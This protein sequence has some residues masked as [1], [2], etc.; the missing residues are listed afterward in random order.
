MIARAVL[1]PD[2]AVD[3]GRFQPFRK[4]GAQ[5]KMIEAQTRIA[6]KPIS[7]VVLERIDARVRMERAQ[8]VGPALLHETRIGRSAFRLD[9]RVV[10]P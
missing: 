6:R 9:E 10:V 4:C 3:I 8:G 7:Q 1:A 5:Q 2:S